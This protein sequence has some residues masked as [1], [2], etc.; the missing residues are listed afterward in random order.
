MLYEQDFQEETVLVRYYNVVF[1]LKFRREI[2]ELKKNIIIKRIESGERI[3]MK[4]VY[5]WCKDQYVPVK[6]R[7]FYRKDLP[8]RANIWN[9]YSYCR[10][11][12]ETWVIETS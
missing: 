3:N 12:I 2:D 10:F 1:Y 4:G 11:R 7:F 8:I 6:M 9:L 5:N